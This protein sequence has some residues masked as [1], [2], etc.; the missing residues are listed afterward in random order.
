QIALLQT[1]ADQAV[2]A[3]RNVRLFNDVQ[4]RT[5]ELAEALEQQTA[6]SE[7]LGVISRSPGELRPVFETMLENAIRICEA[8][9]GNLFLLEREGVFRACAVHG[10][11]DYVDYW[12]REPVINV[13]HPVIPLARL[14]RT[15]QVVH[16]LDL[17]VDASYIERN[18]RIVALVEVARARTLLAVPM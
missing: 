4:T 15:K 5:R 10:E 11:T 17:S 14:T 9:F 6:T 16:V 18:P 8:K 12:R 13:D 1:F 3:I 7:V 2:I